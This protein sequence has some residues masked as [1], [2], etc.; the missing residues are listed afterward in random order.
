MNRPRTGRVENTKDDG[1]VAKKRPEDGWG[2]V[3]GGMK[4]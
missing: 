2:V 3:R 4:A 1:Y